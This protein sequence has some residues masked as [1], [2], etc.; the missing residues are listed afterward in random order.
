MISELLNPLAV[1]CAW[2]K[3]NATIHPPE[4]DAVEKSTTVPT[5]VIDAAELPEFVVTTVTSPDTP[6]GSVKETLSVDGS[7]T[8]NVPCAGRVF[9]TDTPAVTVVPNLVVKLSEIPKD[10]ESD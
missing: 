10:S 6:D 8:S 7:V 3:L 5:N 9:V 2:V 4:H 1:N